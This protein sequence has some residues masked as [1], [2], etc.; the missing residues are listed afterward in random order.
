MFYITYPQKEVFRELTFDDLFS[1]VQIADYE[2]LRMNAK[3]ATRTYCLKEV[4]EK[5]RSKTDVEEMV[6]SLQAFNKQTE[7]LRAVNRGSLYKKGFIPKKKGGL[8]EINAPVPELK[9]ALTYLQVILSGFML[10]DHHDAAYAYVRSRST[11]EAG[12]THQRRNNFW[13]AK[14]DLHDFFGSCDFDFIW[15]MFQM[16]YPFNLIV[17][18]EQGAKEL[19]TALGL[20]MLNN[21]LPQGSPISPW[22]TNVIMIPFDHILSKRLSDFVSK[23]NG[24]HYRFCYTRYADD[25][26]ISSKFQFDYH[27]I[28]H[29]IMDIH[30]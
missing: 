29:L 13:F 1:N 3:G 28:E 6:K 2:Q 15:N 14:F 19:K 12:K 30:T 20:C 5:I 9:N 8:R 26:D 24:R 25:M 22:L 4:T 17:E 11:V 16:I 10:A 23:T 27:E 18:N 21:G 7:N